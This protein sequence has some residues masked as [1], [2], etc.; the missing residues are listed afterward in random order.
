MKKIDVKLIKILKSETTNKDLISNI[1]Y[2]IN[3]NVLDH[4]ETQLCEKVL[5]QI[6]LIG[7]PDLEGALK[8]LNIDSNAFN[9]ILG[10]EK[11]EI[12]EKIDDLILLRKEIENKK[13]QSMASEKVSK[14]IIDKE[15]ADI[16]LNRYVEA[17]HIKENNVLEKLINLKDEESTI[18]ISTS[19]LVTDNIMGGLENGTVTTITGNKVYTTEN[20]NLKNVTTD[21][22]ELWAINIAYKALQNGKNVLYIALGKTDAYIYLSLLSKH[23]C[24]SNFDRP[25]TKRDLFSRKEKVKD[26]LIPVYDDFKGK[27]KNHLIVFD[28]RQFDISTHHNLQR[29]FAYSENDFKTKTKKGIDLIIIDDFTYMKLETNKRSIINKN[30]IANDYY[31]YLRNQSKNFLGTGKSIPILI[32]IDPVD[33]GIG[34]SKNVGN[35]LLEFLLYEVQVLSDNILTIFGSDYLDKTNNVKIQIIKSKKGVMSEAT[36]IIANTDYCSIDDYIDYVD[37]PVSED[38]LI[39]QMLKEDM[40]VLQKENERLKNQLNEIYSK[41]E[42][43]TLEY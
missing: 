40:S 29:L 1:K 6:E 22:K 42:P 39:G 24:N 34:A 4:I 19:N 8:Q 5:E 20:G 14:G 10:Y 13:I 33:S 3:A 38:C 18:D 41:Q 26:S 21:Y 23:S 9:N 37:C 25:L 36:S 35:Y 27:Y 32:T 11:L 2:L 16:F 7:I 12:L 30:I 31:K 15:I 28:E 17:I 43:I